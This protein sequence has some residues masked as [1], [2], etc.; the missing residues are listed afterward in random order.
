MQAKGSFTVKITP[1]T[2]SESS[3]EHS[4]TDSSLTRYMIE[5]LFIGDLEGASQGQ[6][7]GAGS[8]AS[9]SAGYVAIEKVTG[10]I[11]ERIGTFV[12]QHS[13]S[14]NHGDLK[15]TISVVPDS[16]TGELAGLSGTMT[17]ENAGGQHSYEFAYTLGTIQ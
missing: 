2:W 1:L 14:M 16:G 3:P 13:G 10:K 6:M 9:G 8:P 7:L 4:L 17:I 12:L 15:L 5:K 11:H